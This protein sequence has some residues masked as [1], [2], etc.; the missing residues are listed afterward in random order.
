MERIAYKANEGSISTL[1]FLPAV[2]QVACPLQDRLKSLGLTEA[3]IEQAIR[4]WKDIQPAQ[5]NPRL[6]LREIHR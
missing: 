6:S 1:C 5:A 4:Q 3:K 2:F